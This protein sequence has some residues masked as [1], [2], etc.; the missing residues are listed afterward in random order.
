MARWENG[1]SEGTPV[2]MWCAIPLLLAAAPAFGATWTGYLVDSKCYGAEE[3]NVNPWDTAPHADSDMDQ[4][5]R[6][7]AVKPKT[8]AFAVVGA[9]WNRLKFDAEGNAQ[10]AELA[11]KA[12]KTRFLRV[13]VTGYLHQDTIAVTSIS[14]APPGT[15]ST[16]SSRPGI[17][18]E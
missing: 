18:H 6:Y 17:A 3:R 7:C 5:I 15:R 11:R 9:D 1:G 2:K 10:A 4:E 8:R 16:T 12:A 13:D 14:P